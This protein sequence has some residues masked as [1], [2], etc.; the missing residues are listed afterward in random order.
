MILNSIKL[1]FQFRNDFSSEDDFSNSPGR[2]L[3]RKQSLRRESVYDPGDTSDG[4]PPIN[5]S[6]M[7]ENRKMS[8]KGNLERRNTYT[9]RVFPESVTGNFFLELS[10]VLMYRGALINVELTWLKAPKNSRGYYYASVM[11]DRSVL[12]RQFF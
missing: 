10:Q 2:P 11:R 9:A 12:A 6:K 7:S 5:Q 4:I 3:D 8:I 1:K